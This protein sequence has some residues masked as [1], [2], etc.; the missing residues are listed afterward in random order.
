[1]A[2]AMLAMLVGGG[3]FKIHTDPQAFLSLVRKAVPK[4]RALPAVPDP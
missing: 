3:L 2:L 4:L 1:M